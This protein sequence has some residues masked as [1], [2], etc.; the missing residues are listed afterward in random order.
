MALCN[1]CNGELP[2]DGG[3][4][5]CGVCGGGLHYGCSTVS[6]ASWRSMSNPNKAKWRCGECRGRSNYL[7]QRTDSNNSL[8]GNLTDG[9]SSRESSKRKDETVT[10]SKIEALLEV[11]FK[12]FKD[13]IE[14]SL[15]YMSGTVED[16]SKTF[17]DL[18]QKVT[19]MENKQSKLESQN[20]ELMK[21]V[22]K[23]E[24]FV[25][26]MAQE[27]NLTK[28]EIAGIPQD[29]QDCASFTEKVLEKARLNTIVKRGDYQIEKIERTVKQGTT[30]Q[31][32]SMIK[33][34]IINFKTKD[35]RNS[36][37]D[38]LKKEKPRLDTAGISGQQPPIP[39]FIN[40][41]L[42]PYLKKVFYEAK[43]IKND[44]KYEYL[45]VKNGQILL[46]K[47]KDSKVTRLTCLED[48]A[49]I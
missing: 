46:K 26:D 41:Y 17:K 32:K 13:D 24:T 10:L 6:E 7:L 12:S 16:L 30:P 48:L 8:S 5:V 1:S 2:A 42:T 21:R 40:E 37:L 20:Q 31:T 15:E 28:V 33:G 35:M 23:L 19:T 44:K 47:Q 27:G 34:L 3:H 29:V 45:W 38:I 22:K 11:K 49:K 14:K 4:I 25:Q 39:I 36:V 18:Q 43:K 9:G